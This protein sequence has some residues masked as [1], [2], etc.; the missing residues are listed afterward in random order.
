MTSELRGYAIEH[1]TEDWRYVIISSGGNITS[2]ERKLFQAGVRSTTEPIDPD[3][4]FVD[5]MNLLPDD[6]IGTW[7]CVLGGTS[8]R[9]ASH[10][11]AD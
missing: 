8:R 3:G 9:S 11:R 6:M 1:N 10:T 4:E 7:E 5:V 2:A